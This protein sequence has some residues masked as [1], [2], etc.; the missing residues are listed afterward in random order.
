MT[1]EENHD[2]DETPDERP[3]EDEMPDE[4][5]KENATP[6]ERPIEDEIPG[7]QPKGDE[8]PEGQ[9]DGEKP[10]DEQSEKSATTQS[11]PPDSSTSTGETESPSGGLR[12]RE[13]DRIFSLLEDVLEAQALG[14]Q[15]LDQLFSVLEG[16]LTRPPG[17][18]PKLLA[19]F[20]SM[21]E[22]VVLDPDTF[23]QVEVSALLSVFETALAA[24][25]GGEERAEDVVSILDQLIDDPST[26]TPED[27][28]QFHTSIEP[29]IVDVTDPAGKYGQLL[30]TSGYGTFDPAVFE[31]DQLDSFRLARIGAAMTQRATGHTLESGMRTGTRMAYAAMN[32]QSPSILLTEL[33]AITLDELR[34]S[35]IDIGSEQEEWLEAH[36]DSLVD[37]RPMTREQLQKRGKR[38]LDR[39]AEVGHDEGIHPA[40][41]SI[42]SDLAAD[43]ARILR[44]LA[45]DGVQACLD[46]YD[47]RYIPFSK[48]LVARRLSMVGSDAGCRHP[49]R[50]PIYL[51]NLERLGLIRFGDE[52]VEN[53]KRYQVLDAQ[54]HIEAAMEKAK[55]PTT[56]YGNIRLTEFGLEF[57]TV[58]L[59]VEINHDRQRRRFRGEEPD[60]S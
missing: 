26:V 45:Q 51:Q 11:T 52:P 39:S 56:S 23:Q 25:M 32:S 36:Q 20:V 9:D 4:R 37:D 46:I 30:G 40:F 54:P 14:G 47:R 43:E 44:L 2:E 24:T 27:V 19:E 18:D 60:S 50:T 7:E 41:A 29:L 38:L 1:A 6:G 21:L 59:P 5:P 13:I 48:E 16:L 17:T 57:C 3:I 8:P 15:E 31:D 58:C 49:E 12:I 34:R 22:Q 55:R 53:L 42:L 28:E 35:G 10:V 33:K